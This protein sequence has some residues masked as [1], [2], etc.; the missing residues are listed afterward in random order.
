MIKE[1]G[2]DNTLEKNIENDLIKTFQ[3]NTHYFE[4]MR[5]HNLR[6]GIDEIN[7]E[8]DVKSLILENLNGKVLDAGCGE[9]S[10]SIW[11]SRKNPNTNIFSLDISSLGIKL[12]KETCDEYNITNIN[13]IIG[14]VREIPTINESFDLIICQSVFEHV[15]GIEKILNEFYRVLKNGGK[16]IIRVG[17]GAS[18]GKFSIIRWLSKKKDVQMIA[19]SLTLIPGNYKNHRENFDVC[20]IPSYVLINNLKKIGFLV[21]NYSTFPKHVFKQDF[22]EFSKT[23]R[24]FIRILLKF[25]K[26]PPIRHMGPT[27]IVSAV[28]GKL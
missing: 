11:M 15:I 10:I 14:D 22:N 5:N 28:K 13:F 21:E 6:N 25:Y 8:S 20:S 17:N 4:M 27:T 23:K 7:I 16:V 2:L 9:C 24:F 18:G 1:H 19:P 26:F 3:T 12:G